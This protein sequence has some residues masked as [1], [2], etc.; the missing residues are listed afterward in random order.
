MAAPDLVALDGDAPLDDLLAAIDTDGGAIIK[1]ALSRHTV[2]AFASDIASTTAEMAAGTRTGAERMAEFWGTKT[3]RYTRLSWRSPA[4]Q[5]ILLAPHLRAVS[6][7]LLLP[8]CDSYWLNTGQM[9]IIGPGETEQMWHRDAG[10]W[11]PLSAPTAPEVTIS[12]MYAIGAFSHDNGGTRVVP[13]SHRWDD[14]GRVPTPE[15][16]VSVEMDPGDGFIYTGRVIHNG[17]PNS[18]DTARAGLHVSF[19]CGWLTPEEALPISTPW[20]TAQHLSDTAQQL[21]GWKAYGVRSRLW[22]VDYEDIEVSGAT[23]DL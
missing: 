14:Y 21:L 19:V 15:E 7:A 12:C 5:D 17:G 23:N 11:P 9:M 3:K 1:G 20:S 6:D 8:N 10:N 18:T 2:D 16:Y 13:G 22:T 4:F